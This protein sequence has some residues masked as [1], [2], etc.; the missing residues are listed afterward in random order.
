METETWTAILLILGGALA[1]PV[2]LGLIG[3]ICG[4]VKDWWVDRV[5]H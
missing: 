4:S 3:M 2:V 5:T 1:A